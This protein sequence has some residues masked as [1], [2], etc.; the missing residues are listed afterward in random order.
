MSNQYKLI[1]EISGGQAPFPLPPPH[2]GF[3]QVNY[4]LILILISPPRHNFSELVCKIT[5]PFGMKMHFPVKWIAS[6]NT[7][8]NE[9]AFSCEVAYLFP[10]KWLFSYEVA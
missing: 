1:S 4:M 9:V 5:M 8:S 10:M 3:A 7:F 2:I 6:F